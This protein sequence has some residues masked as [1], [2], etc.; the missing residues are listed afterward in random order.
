MLVILRFL[1]FF[2]MLG[3]LLVYLFINIKLI[4]KGSFALI[5][6]VFFVMIGVFL[7]V[8]EIILK[9]GIYI[10]KSFLFL[11]LFFLYLIINITINRPNDLKRMLI[12]TSGGIILFYVLGSLISINL[13]SIKEKVLNSNRFLNIF[14]FLCIIFTL[15]FVTLLVDTFTTLMINIRADLF[16]IADLNGA[17]QRPGSFL[18]IAFFIYSF[19]TVFFI[20]VNSYVKRYKFISFILFGLYCLVTIVAMMLSQMIGSN[21]A[22]VNLIGLLFI[23]KMFYILINFLNSK[24][25][26]SNIKLNIKKIF[27][28]K[29]TRKLFSSI[30]IAL[31]VVILLLVIFV[32]TLDID[33]DKFR[34]FG[35]GSGE[36]SSV[37]NRLALWDNFLVHF[38]YNPIFGNIAVDCLTTGKGSYVHSFPASLLTHLG[39]VGFLLFFVYLYTAIK[40]TLN[41]NN[42]LYFNNLFSLYSIVVFIGIFVIASLAVF[43]TWIPLWFLLGLIFPPVIFVKRKL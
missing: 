1:L 28:S 36:I 30:F 22:L 25:L 13:L 11:V 4:G 19:I 15:L 18:L 21:N 24:Y 2:I 6:L 29:L 14:N 32:N 39:I 16:L 10:K 33:L 12:A 9:K 37:S 5:L 27:L 34:I 40:E 17:Y 7:I 43:I 41:N 23:T 35:Y 38:N 26:L 42:N 31:F 3:I 8:L 20:F